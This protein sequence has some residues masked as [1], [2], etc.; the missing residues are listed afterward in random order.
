M[1][2]KRISPM[3]AAKMQGAVCALMG[4]LFGAMFSLI[5]MTIG[6]MASGLGG[7][8]SGGAGMFGMMM[9]VGAIIFV[10]I[11]YGIFGFIA[12]AIGAAIYNLVA[13]WMGGLEIET[14]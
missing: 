1:V 8:N 3:S 9:G 10:P 14:Q 11:F 13:G 7:N 12:G 6:S 4:L 5:S 2:I